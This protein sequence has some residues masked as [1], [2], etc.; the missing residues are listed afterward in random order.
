M[1]VRLTPGAERPFTIVAWHT[2]TGSGTTESS[3]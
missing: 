3:R 1:E 2:P